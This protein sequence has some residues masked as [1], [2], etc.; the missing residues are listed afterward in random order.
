MP[1]QDGICQD[2]Q[3]FTPEGRLVCETRLQRRILDS[4]HAPGTSEIPQVSVAEPILAVQGSPFLPQQ[5]PVH[6]YEA[7]KAGSVTLKEP[8][9]QDDTLLGRHVDHGRDPRGGIKASG[10][11]AVGL[12]FV[13]NI[14]KSS[15]TPKQRL[16]FL[17]FVLD[18]RQMTIALPETKLHG[19][20]KMCKKMVR[21]EVTSLR[22][23]A[24]L[25]GTMVASHPAI[26]PAP[27]HYR[28][29]ER[30]KSQAL[31]KG[32]PYKTEVQVDAGMLDD[33]Q[34][35]LSKHNGR[36][37][38]VS[39]WDVTIE[40]D[41]F[42]ISWAGMY[43]YLFPPFALIPG[44]LDKISREEVS[45]VL[46]A[47]VWPG[48]LWF[49]QLLWKLMRLPILLPHTQDIVSDPEGQ[50][51]PPS[52][53]GSSANGRLACLRHSFHTEG[54]SDRVIEVIRRSW[55]KSTESAY[56]GAMEAVG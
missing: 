38:Q 51:H 9:H 8:E 11:S 13:I 5:C 36:T 32:L 49:P 22:E 44:C 1:F 10:D 19:L 43:P 7:D 14:P 27:L 3:E 42:S 31:R 52:S 53:E 17:E 20:Q 24:Q 50:A 47:P 33:L 46:I 48:Q 56:S 28:C 16:E 55:R 29:L 39:Q 21:L 23:L 30:T 2:S 4:A 41:A 40:S 18:T 12:G 35:K 25:L 6:I 26:L 34:D 54:L 45:A 37:L 15:L